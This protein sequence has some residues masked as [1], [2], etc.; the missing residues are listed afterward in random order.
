ME[1]KGLG[2]YTTRELMDELKR[3]IAETEEA[4]VLLASPPSA[5][6]IA[7]KAYWDEWRAYV[8][9]YPNATKEQFKNSKS[10]SKKSSHK[11]PR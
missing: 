11:K 7:K 3:R 1:Q 10:R 5:K 8:A 4:R 9:K 2:Q 6:S